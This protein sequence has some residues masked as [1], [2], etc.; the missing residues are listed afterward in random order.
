MQLASALIIRNDKLLVLKK[1]K[2]NSHYILPGGKL[3]INESPEDALIREL[4]EELSMTVDKSQLEFF[5]TIKTQAIFENTHLT[6][7]VYYVDY[8][9]DFK[10]SGEIASYFWLE[11]NRYKNYEH[12]LANLLKTVLEQFSRL[13]TN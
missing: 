4:K 1:K 5:A 12:E 7:S 11:I 2:N 9:G 8:Q 6:S 3:E 10:I 13:E